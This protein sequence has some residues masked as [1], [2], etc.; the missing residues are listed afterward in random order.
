MNVFEKDLQDTLASA[1][2][3]GMCAQYVVDTLIRYATALCQYAYVGKESYDHYL[4]NVLQMILEEFEEN[5]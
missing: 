2:E 4:R 1:K 5:K 3:K